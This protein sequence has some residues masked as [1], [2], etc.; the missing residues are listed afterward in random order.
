MQYAN[1]GKAGVKVS[2]ICLGCWS[3]GNA[4]PW[5]IEMPE[6]RKVI[7][8]AIDLGINFFDTANEYSHG[9]S[10]EILGE[11]L[12]NSREDFVI[13]T[14]V[15]FPMGSGPNERGLSRL[16][17]LRQVKGSLERLQTD[18][19][20]LYQ[21]H[22]WD[23][24]TPIEETLR[25]L[26]N[27]VHDGRV[28]YIGASSMWAWQ[29]LKALHT[30]DRLGLERFVSMQNHYNLCYREEEREMMP[31]CLEEGVGLI[32]WSPLGHGF[33]TGK[34]RRGETPDS[35]RYRS[36]KLFGG[37][38]FHPENFDVLERAQE[39]AREK[40]V[41]VAQIALAWILRKG[42]VAPIIGAT[43]VEHVED[44]ANALELRLSEDDVKRLEES[45]KPHPIWGHR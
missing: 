5:M 3:F 45:Y 12:R 19:V 41:P 29:F 32:P 44:A 7:S 37:R 20:D 35:A 38:Y 40:D 9:R 34:Y 30:S 11:C 1:L 8:K 10:E 43:K 26:D 13:A 42:V 17:I 27:L 6:A 24:E 18:H 4:A 16:H 2:R 39:V 15:Y 22:R 28:R 23:Y 14:K 31:L 33:L 25:T 21:T 36:S